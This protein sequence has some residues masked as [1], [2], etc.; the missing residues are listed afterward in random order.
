[1][2]RRGGSG[3]PAGCERHCRGRQQ[4]DSQQRGSW[5]HGQ[6]CSDADRC[7]VS[8]G[9]GHGAPDASGDQ[10][11][12]PALRKYRVDGGA[13]GSRATASPKRDISVPPRKTSP[14]PGAPWATTCTGQRM[15]QATGK[16]IAALT[17]QPEG[18]NNPGEHQARNDPST[19]QDSTSL[20]C[21]LRGLYP[22][23]GTGSPVLRMLP[24]AGPGSMMRTP[25][26][27]RTVRPRP[28]WLPGSRRAESAKSEIFA[29]CCQAPQDPGGAGRGD[30]LPA[31][32]VPRGRHDRGIA[33]RSGLGP[34]AGREA[35]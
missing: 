21:P 35:P 4:R 22:A 17:R 13:T 29:V 30:G 6:H 5:V 32:A 9:P 16:A 10:G 15:S 34:G 18:A 1:M 7:G 33:A 27:A 19:H 28:S 11:F 24:R 31:R 8:R 23:P 20:S 2:G 26:P 14:E 25:D 3:R 12:P